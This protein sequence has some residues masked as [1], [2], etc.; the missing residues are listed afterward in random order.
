MNRRCE[1]ELAK[2][3]IRIRQLDRKLYSKIKN[4]QF[5]VTVK[6]FKEEELMY[7]NC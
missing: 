7:F 5:G 4:V 6:D 3:E 1:S 2:E